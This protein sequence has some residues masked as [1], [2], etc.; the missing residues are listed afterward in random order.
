MVNVVIRNN[1]D[2]RALLA[3]DKEWIQFSVSRGRGVPVAKRG[4]PPEGEVYILKAGETVERQFRLDPFY[5][6]SE[7]GEYGVRA[8]VRVPNW[9]GAVIPS[10]QSQLQVM[11][12][13]DLVSIERGVSTALGGAAPEVRRYTLQKA[14]VAGRHFMYLRTSDNNSPS[15]KVFNVLPLGTLI[16]RARGEFGFQ[17]DA[18]GV[19]HVFFQCHVRHFLYCTLNTHG[20]LLRRQMFMTDPFKGTPALGRDVRGHFV[21]NGGQRVQSE[22]DFPAPLKRPRGLPAKELGLPNP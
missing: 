14:T 13:Q 1:T 5:D 8:M 10:R 16:H 20:K 2:K 6:F 22:W 17:V 3:A 15:F 7:P 21:V 12:G 11:R 4:R 18:S 19:V 9:D